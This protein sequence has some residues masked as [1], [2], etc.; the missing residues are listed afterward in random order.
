MATRDSLYK[1]DAVIL[2]DRNIGEY[3]RVFVIFSPIYGKIDSIAKGIRKP[4]SKMSGN[5][6]IFSH[7]YL[8]L[9]EGSTFD[10]ITQVEVCNPHYM[11]RED[12]LRLTCASYFL[13]LID[14]SVFPGQENLELF[15]LVLSGLSL[16]EYHDNLELVLRYLEMNFLNILGYRPMLERCQRCG[17]NFKSFPVKFIFSSGGAFCRDC[18]DMSQGPQFGISEETLNFLR[19]LNRVLPEKLANNSVS[20]RTYGES[21]YLLRNFLYYYVNKEI[22]SLKLLDTFMVK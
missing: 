4:S 16:L 21:R 12:L 19:C 7:V 17:E 14:L 1:T 6:E 10:V 22:K 20:P 5:I 13:E 15:T 8:M 9:S 11:L 2:K 3:D 18:T